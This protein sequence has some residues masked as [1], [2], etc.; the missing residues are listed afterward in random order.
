M[1]RFQ[2]IV[3]I[4]LISFLFSCK[5][6][7]DQ[8]KTDAANMHQTKHEQIQKTEDGKSEQQL[9]T[10]ILGTWKWHKTRCCFRTP[11]TTYADSLSYSRIIKFSDGTLQTFHGDT[12]KETSNYTVKYGLTEHDDRPVLQINGR[13][14]FLYFIHD[15]LV[16]DYGYMDLQTEYYLRFHP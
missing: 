16:I 5:T 13:P 7:K 15:T 12:L 2:I 1:L 14:A 6:S 8:S 3:L 4:L 9:A 10:R 11:K